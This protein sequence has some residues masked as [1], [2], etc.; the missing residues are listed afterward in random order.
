MTTRRRGI[1]ASYPFRPAMIAER[2]VLQG[3]ER[4]YEGRM[5]GLCDPFS[6]GIGRNP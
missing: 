3:T 1:C 6:S 5:V 4:L 2:R